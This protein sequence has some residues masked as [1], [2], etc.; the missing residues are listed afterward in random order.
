[1]SEDQTAALT[2]IGIA[3]LQE[4][5]DRAP[6]LRE[7]SERDRAAIATAVSKA[8]HRGFNRG[9]AEGAGEVNEAWAQHV[10]PQILAKLPN[11]DL[12]EVISNISIVNPSGETEPEADPWL[13]D[14]GNG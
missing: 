9:V 11:A 14:Y 13:E 4:L 8:T 3:V 5:F 1:M 7:V 10:R 2:A 6:A 12:P